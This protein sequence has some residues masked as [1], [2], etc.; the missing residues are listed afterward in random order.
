MDEDDDRFVILQELIERPLMDAKA[1]ADALPKMSAEEPAM[2]QF[3]QLLLEK[4]R[5]PS[6]LAMLTAAAPTPEALIVVH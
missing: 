1:Y 5:G 6:T 2:K 3:V 4:M